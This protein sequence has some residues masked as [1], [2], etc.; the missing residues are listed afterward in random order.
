M[1]LWI[2]L[3]SFFIVFCF[4]NLSWAQK[5]YVEGEVIVRLRDGVSQT[6]TYS[7]MGKAQGEQ[8]L[9]LK[10]SLPK[11]KMYHYTFKLGK[12]TEQMIQELKEDPNVEYAEPNYIL[13][14]AS[15]SEI[16]VMSV[17]EIEAFAREMVS[18]YP[19]TSADIRAVDLWD[20]FME[21]SDVSDPIVVAVI[22]TG[23]DMEHDVFVE[24]D[25]IWTNIDEVPGN[26]VDDDNNNYVDDI[27]GW[28][29]VNQSPVIIDDDGHGT[30]VSGIILGVGQNLLEDPLAISSIRLMPLKFL[31]ENG[32]G[33]TADAVKAIYYAIENGA[34]VLNNSWG[35]SNYSVAL[36]EAIVY[37]YQK[38]AIFV[39][40]S[41][42]NGSDNDTEPIYP[43]SYDVPHV[44]SVAATTVEDQL[45]TFSNFGSNSVDV[46]S[47]GVFIWSTVPDNSYGYSSGTSMAAPFVSGL[48]ALMLVEVPE[49]QGYQVK[50]IIFQ[51]S[52]HAEGLVS[53]TSQE[54]RIN[55]QGAIQNA[56]TAL[57]QKSQPEY[58]LTA[59]ERE[60]AAAV[61][62]A[63][64]CG[65]V[66][67]GPKGG[68]GKGGGWKKVFLFCSI[69]MIPVLLTKY[70]RRHVSSPKRQHDRFQMDSDIRIK[71][72][73]SNFVGSVS[74]VSLGGLQVNTQALLEEGGIV[75]MTVSSPD[76][77]EQIKVQGQ[78]VWRK[79][80]EA[81][82][83]QFARED[84]GS[85]FEF[86]SAWVSPS[87]SKN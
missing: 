10:T 46:G 34:R 80:K 69:M 32:I 20:D 66:Y 82:G 37:S 61:S 52:D 31:D 56:Q 65:T 6:E 62:G 33:S 64:G 36:H 47:P 45:A 38:G 71:I 14:K 68:S 50:S 22:D 51:E 26:K 42:N 19:H 23:L 11:M 13:T 72:D 86:L 76:G 44:M 3:G 59:T 85:A 29:F 12:S 15:V 24:S 16:Q 55:I 41:G 27:H 78:V 4:S 7:F 39:A 25:A 74:T 77:K 17:E 63:G 49:M 30:H 2:W 8:G 70:L 58:T 21:K 75:N 53:K 5:Q 43:A 79:E 9:S 83:V 60:L 48:A 57:V 87:A 81:Y 73:G 40:A 28:N 67:R 35:G 1:N 54:S 84:G 18:Q